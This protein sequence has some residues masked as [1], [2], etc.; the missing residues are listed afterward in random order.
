[1]L[2][3]WTQFHIAADLPITFRRAFRLPITG[4]FSQ[5]VVL[6]ALTT[7][8]QFVLGQSVGLP[9]PRLLTTMPMGGNPGS[10]V[11]ITITGENLDP[12]DELVFTE[13]K[14]T[15]KC[16]LDP[17]GQP[18]P[19]KYV[20]SI[21]ADCPTGLYEARMVTRLGLSASRVF[22]VG[23]LPEVM[24]SKPNTTL[25]SAMELKVNSVC[26]AVMTTRAVDYYTFEARKGQ[27]VIA[28]CSSRGIDS[29]LEAVLIIANAKG[30]DLMAER[31]GGVL[32]FV[33]PEDGKYVIKVHE[34][35]FG[36]GPAY[37]YRLALYES[38][39]DAAIAKFPSTK[40]VSSISWPP[41]GLPDQSAMTEIEP[42]NEA[43][44]AQR[45]TLPCDISG[46]FFPA[47][48]VDV[49]EFEAKKG[50]V[51]WVEVASE[52]LGLPTDPAVVVQRVSGTGDAQKLTD[53][54]E[55]SDIPSP[56]K[57]SS[58]GYSYD[59]PP[60]NVGSTDVLGKIVIQEDGVHR[61]Q[62]T[63]LFG[64]T[65]N[66]PR[67]RYRLVI[68]Q[69]QPDFALAGW[70]LHFE[71]RNG[72][73]NAVSKPLA[74]RR[75]A[76][77]ALEV[78]T[79]RRDG[80]D[81]EIE[82]EM[83]GLPEGV[84][85]QGLK[86]PAGKSR[87]IMLITAHENAPRSLTSAHFVG[88]AT[89]DGKA[90]TRPCQLA[91]MSW[92]ILD[93]WNDIPSPR[94]LMD[95]PISVGGVESVPVSIRAEKAEAYEAAATD[96]LTIPLVLTRHS[97]FSGDTL[98][99]KALGAGFEGVKS[100]NISLSADKAEAVLDLAALKTPPGDY[101]LCFYGS[102]VAKY[103]HRLDDVAAAENRVRKLEDEQKS[104]DAEVAQLTEVAKNA[105]QEGKADAEAAVTAAATKQKSAQATLALATEQLKKAN[106]V[107]KPNDIVDIVVS[108]PITIRV[109][110]A[111]KK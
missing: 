48:D 58:N 45:I 87:G 78:V 88:K 14:I 46:Q 110:P 82:L 106:D 75:G 15:A 74:L 16:K 8:S 62:L 83:S 99:L 1:M 50:E 54:A 22:S 23:R 65:R 94:L 53:V 31:R 109:K 13:P 89:I 72:D 36:G 95:V 71:L 79:V 91:S 102:A 34:L 7:S 56:V 18:E 49:F 84:T 39:P 5:L 52:R 20:V 28:N 86:I 97:E 61:L 68:R 98:S 2:N 73:R 101:V 33:A 40:S 90:V 63:D 81:G 3:C 21:D 55:F 38:S 43:S 67:N 70:G 44:V 66:D 29:K 25:A 69:A 4:L 92:P 107:A 47:A 64:G 35:T 60:Y 42:N 57:V 24:P 108:E 96:K 41:V 104:I 37:F 10:Q 59:G 93:A 100:F 76:T 17:N 105:A 103:R 26:N 19:N 9:A 77:V 32:D 27:R 11:E 85:A 80:F 6:I 51:W 30:N 12:G 111:E